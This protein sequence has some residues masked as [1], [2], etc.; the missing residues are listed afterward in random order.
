MRNMKY[1]VYLY[2]CKNNKSTNE[3][4]AFTFFRSTRLVLYC[5]VC[6]VDTV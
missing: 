6:S 1:P 3:D 5:L 2:I 4:G